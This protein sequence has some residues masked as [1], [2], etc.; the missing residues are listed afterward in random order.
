MDSLDTTP[1]LSTREFK[2]IIMRRRGSVAYKISDFLQRI[3]SQ[4]GF[5]VAVRMVQW[6]KES[7]R[8]TH[9]ERTTKLMI[10]DQTRLWKGR[11]LDCRGTLSQCTQARRCQFPLLHRYM[12]AFFSLE[13]GTSKVKD[14]EHRIIASK[15][16]GNFSLSLPGF[17]ILYKM[18]E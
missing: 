13:L 17:F 2:R 12:H 4:Q 11:L 16:P 9:E 8:A 6:M 18:S 7:V 15:S 10:K 3:S 14:S 1:T 5:H